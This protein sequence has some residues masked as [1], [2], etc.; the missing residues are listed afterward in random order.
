[1]A[2]NIGSFMNTGPKT[3]PRTAAAP[4]N[5]TASITVTSVDDDPTITVPASVPATED[6]AK[7][8]EGISISDVDVEDADDELS[9]TLSVTDGSLSVGSYQGPT[10][11]L[12]GTKDHING[13]L[14]GAGRSYREDEG[15]SGTTPDEAGFTGTLTQITGLEAVTQTRMKDI[16]S[17]G[18]KKFIRTEYDPD[19]TATYEDSTYREV[20][21]TGTGVDKVWSFCLLYTSPSPRDG[22]LSRM[23]SSA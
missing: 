20:D 2:E 5:A 3:G 6:V 22:L 12:T 14:A 21:S 16:Y 7:L 15:F 23:P 8:I 1:M 19:S 11:T 18:A 17:I 4:A 9:V 13:K 10:V